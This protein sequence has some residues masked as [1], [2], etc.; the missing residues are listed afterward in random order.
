M[1]RFKLASADVTYQ[2]LDGEVVAI[3][4]T[5]GVYFNLRGAAAV[6]FDA[7]AQGLPEESLPGLFTSPP[8]NAAEQLGG[9][10][11]QFVEAELLVVD[12]PAETAPMPNVTVTEWTPPV[13]ESYTDMQQLLLADPIHDVG[14]EAWPRVPSTMP[15]SSSTGT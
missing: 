7:L 6:T 12:V 8:Q 11:R 3:H 13:F 15:G 14:A 10:R 1:A 5:K 2:L 4:F 9:L